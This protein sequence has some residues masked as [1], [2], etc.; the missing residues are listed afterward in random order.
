MHIKTN[1]LFCRADLNNEG[2]SVY[3]V[4]KL[5]TGQQS[6]LRIMPESG[7]DSFRKNDKKPSHV[8]MGTIW[9]K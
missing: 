3:K 2:R 9:I 6:S 1:T 8:F 5:F 4:E 7:K